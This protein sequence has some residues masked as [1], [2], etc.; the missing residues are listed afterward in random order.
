VLNLSKHLGRVLQ[1]YG[2]AGFSV[3]TFYLLCGTVVECIPSKKWYLT[4]AITKGTPGLLEA[5][6]QQA[7][8]QSEW[9]TILFKQ[10]GYANTWGVHAG[11]AGQPFYCLN[12][13]WVLKHHSFTKLPIPDQIIR[14]VN[15]IDAWEQQGQAFWFLNQWL[16]P[17]K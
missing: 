3:R 11:T 16:K 10:H 4:G 7:L 15:R 8:P 5:W 9:Q 13:G 17:F 12:T 14:C 6:L 2:C 1:V